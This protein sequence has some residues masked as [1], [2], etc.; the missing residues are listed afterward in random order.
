[1]GGWGG[2]RDFQACVISLPL[3]HSGE[4]LLCKGGDNDR[5]FVFWCCWAATLIVVYTR[6]PLIL[7][8]SWRSRG[9]TV[10]RLAWIAQRLV[11]SKRPTR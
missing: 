1:M 5:R 9:M 11:S 3:R 6:S 7:R 2:V 8:L 10:T 4:N